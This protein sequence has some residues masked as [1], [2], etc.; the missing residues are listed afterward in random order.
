VPAIRI[1]TTIPGSST[2]SSSGSTG[3]VNAS[4]MITLQS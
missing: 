4:A 3:S 1:G 2:V